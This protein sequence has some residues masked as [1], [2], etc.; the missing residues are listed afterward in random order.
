M[1]PLNGNQETTHKST[2]QQEIVSELNDIE[3]LPEG[4]FP[5]N[6]KLIQKYQRLEPRIIAKYKDGM[7]HKGAFSGGSNID[8]NLK[9]CKDNIV[10]LSKTQSYVLHWYLTYILHP[11]M[12]RT[13][14]KFFQHLYWT[15]N[16]DAFRKEV[17][18]CDTCQHINRSKKNMVN[19]QLS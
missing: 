8:L 7:Y 12:D 4:N 9:M 15:A 14:A 13:E 17:S 19:Y 2:Y 5:I 6:L 16:R 18:N 1:I 11:G 3:E 10:I